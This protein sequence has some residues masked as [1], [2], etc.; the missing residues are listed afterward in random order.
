MKRRTF[1]QWGLAA[2]IEGRWAAAL[3]AAG[4]DDAAD[5][6]AKAVAGGQVAAAV[7]HVAGPKGAATRAFGRA[8]SADAMFLLGSISKPLCITALMTLY[9]RG[10]FGLDDP[11]KKFLPA[12]VGDGRDAV[13][14]RHLLTHTSGLPDQLPENGALRKGHA[15]LAEFVAHAVRASLGFAAG[16]RYQYSSMGALLAA[17][18][19]QQISRVEIREFVDRA[20]FQPLGMRHSALGLGRFAMGD[21][22]PCQTERAAPEAG[23][24][25]PAAR[26]WDWNSPYWRKL[27][28]PW[29]GAHAAAPDVARWLGEF[30]HAKGDVVKP[31]TAKLMTS[32]QNGPGIKPRGL[33]FDV[34]AAAGSP[35]CSDKTFGH[36]GSTGTLCW[37][38][39]ATETTCVV[40]TSLPAG[41][42]RPHP[43][44]LASQ[45][46][47]VETRNP[48]S[49]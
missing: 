1:L 26:D 30:L 35:G 38:D 23:G 5:V 44:D 3:R 14:I 36:T 11:V 32:N 2:A 28:A 29:G 16:S 10:E 8:A 17:Q 7:L 47:A 42:V 22:I 37:A 48:K 21:M 20:V 40:L 34:G 12:F 13:T 18:V 45:R 49:E 39:P 27:G 46:V 33:G 9:D 43:R 15:G 25:D 41:A 6:L 4:P 19:A 31:A 24:G